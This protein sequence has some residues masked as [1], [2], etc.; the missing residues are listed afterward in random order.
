MKQVDFC[1]STVFSFSFSLIWWASPACKEV[2]AFMALSIDLEAKSFGYMLREIV[3]LLHISCNVDSLNEFSLLFVYFRLWCLAYFS[4]PVFCW[5]YWWCSW[6]YW[7]FPATPFYNDQWLQ[8]LDLRSCHQTMRRHQVLCGARQISSW[9]IG[10]IWNLTD[11]LVLADL[12][13]IAHHVENTL[14][15]RLF[16]T[17]VLICQP[18]VLQVPIFVPSERVFDTNWQSTRIVGILYW[19]KMQ[20]T[21]FKSE[22]VWYTQ[23]WFLFCS[24]CEMFFKSKRT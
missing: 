17:L 1:R 23:C 14:K 18:S 20:K 11:I 2:N 8:G 5:P 4:V 24:I 7:L 9:Y 3:F 19:G 13:A 21:P 6:W 10:S 12:S 15:F 22:F 16:Q